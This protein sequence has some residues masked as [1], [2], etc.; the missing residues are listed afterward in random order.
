MQD[1]AFYPITELYI[2]PVFRDRADYE[3]RTGSQA[4]PF[5]AARKKQYWMD[6]ETAGQPPAAIREYHVFQHGVN[7]IEKIQVP[8]A[9]AASVNIPGRY[10]YPPYSVEPT[11]AVIVGPNGP[12]QLN[13]AILSDRA[14]ADRLAAE[15]GGQVVENPIFSPGSPWVIDWRGETRRVWQIRLDRHLLSAALLLKRQASHGV[16]APGRWEIEPDGTPLWIHEP[17]AVDNSLGELYPPIRPLQPNEAIHIPPMG[18]P[19]VYRT[20]LES[21]YNPGSGSGSGVDLELRAKVDRIAAD[22]EDIL[23]ILLSQ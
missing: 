4:L 5:D 11:T 21:P 6:E 7:K 16:G 19:I 14:D 23:G 13:A 3:A 12:E 18:L 2:T 8:A 10:V 17:S 20:D 15:L 22:V 1:K 9:T